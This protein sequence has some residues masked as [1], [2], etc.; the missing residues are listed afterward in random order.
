MCLLLFLQYK[1]FFCITNDNFLGVQYKFFLCTGKKF[2][3]WKKF[4]STQYK[5]LPHYGAGFAA[6]WRGFCRLMAC[7]LPH[8]VIFEAQYKSLLH[9]SREG[10]V[11]AVLWTACCCQKGER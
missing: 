7:V 2:V 1:C 11:K 4:L 9:F 3:S 6:L 8:Y 5:L 10:G